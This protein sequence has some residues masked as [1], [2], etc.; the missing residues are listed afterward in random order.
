MAERRAS[1]PTLSRPHRKQ[2]E[3][4]ENVVV[5]AGNGEESE[6]GAKARSGVPA[7]TGERERVRKHIKM[8]RVVD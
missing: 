8:L 2:R 1:Q 5:R 4:T 6:G 3:L 7:Q